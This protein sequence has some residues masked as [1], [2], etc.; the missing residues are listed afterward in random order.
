MKEG[1]RQRKPRRSQKYGEGGGKK[2]KSGKGGLQNFQ[3]HTLR[4]SNGTA[5]TEF[6]TKSL[7][8]VANCPKNIHNAYLVSSIS[9][10][11]PNVTID[12]RSVINPNTRRWQRVVI[13][14]TIWRV[15]VKSFS[16]NIP[17]IFVTFVKR[18]AQSCYILCYR[19]KQCLPLYYVF[20]STFSTCRY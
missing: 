16:V 7:H 3:F 13:V 14:I 2:Q 17:H 19:E 18:Y 5:L 20:L 6:K 15:S 4:I 11:S 10:I 9:V 12:E 8:V 1:V